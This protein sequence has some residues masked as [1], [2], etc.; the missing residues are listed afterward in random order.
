MNIYNIVNAR[1]QDYIPILSLSD[2]PSL[3][4]DETMCHQLEMYINRLVTLGK[5]PENPYLDEALL[6]LTLSVFYG[7]GY[8][9]YQVEQYSRSQQIAD[10]FVELVNQYGASEH[11][12]NFY[13]DKMR[14]SPKYIQSVV[15][16]TTGRTAY[17]WIEDVVIQNAK[18]LLHD[19]RMTLQQ[20]SAQLNFCDQSYFGAF[21]KRHVGMTP[22]QY[23]SRG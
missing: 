11:Q 5:N 20:I 7:V 1:M 16:N 19:K 17:A 23:R 14:L 18:Q 8:Q 13:A 3:E 9:K 15:K 4:L 2:A 6:H 12:I 22:K 10:E 21:F